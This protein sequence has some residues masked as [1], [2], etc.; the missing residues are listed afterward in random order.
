MGGRRA[1]S[2][3]R[4]RWEIALLVVCAL[5]LVAGAVVYLQVRAD[6]KLATVATPLLPKTPAS[7]EP[8]VK[9]GGTLE[10]TARR[11]AVTFIRTALGR[12]ELA[13]AW[14]LA[15]PELRSSVTREQWLRG[16]L[17]FTPFPIANLETSGFD[18]VGHSPGQVLLQVLLVPKPNTGYV[19]T[20]FDMTLV[21]KRAKGPWR[22]SY[23]LP[24]A[25]PG[26]YTEPG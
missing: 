25:P 16:E 23:F 8:V 26:M 13:K 14:N 9:P 19:P 1:D 2:R 4:E 7:T 6:S 17:P 20:R 18:V 10:P 15:T 5:L 22:V 24:Y 21:R 12:V 11:T 3:L